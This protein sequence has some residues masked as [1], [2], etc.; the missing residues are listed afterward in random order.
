MKS[1]VIKALAIVTVLLATSTQ[2]AEEVM[3]ASYIHITNV[4]IFDGGHNKRTNG[5]VLMK[6]IL[7]RLLVLR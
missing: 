4:A 5:S 7:L 2:A 6:T 1:T 3:D